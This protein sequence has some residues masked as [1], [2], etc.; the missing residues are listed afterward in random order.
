MSKFLKTTFSMIFVSLSILSCS[1]NLLDTSNYK[2]TDN[3]TI[4]NKEEID[5]LDKEYSQFNTKA[6]TDGYLK[7]KLSF[8]T[9]TNNSNKLKK[10]LYYLSYRQ[11]NIA[12]NLLD[13]EVQLL[14][15]INN[16]SGILSEK[17]INQKFSSVF[18]DSP[19]TCS[20]I[21]DK[22][23]FYSSTK[24]GRDIETPILNLINTYQSNNITLLNGNETL[25]NSMNILENNMN[26]NIQNFTTSYD[27]LK[28]SA[29]SISNT[30]NGL[31][32]SNSAQ[33]QSQIVN[34]SN[35]FTTLKT[36]FNSFKQSFESSLNQLNIQKN[37]FSLKRNTDSNSMNTSLSI[38]SNKQNVTNMDFN[39]I[40]SVY[41]SCSFSAQENNSYQNLYQ[42][43][44][45]RLYS[46][47]HDIQYVS[48]LIS[49]FNQNYMIRID[50]ISNKLNNMNSIHQY[51]TNNF[52]N[53]FQ[54]IQ[55]TLQDLNNM[56]QDRYS[57]LACN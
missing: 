34:L 13:K 3:S 15:Q 38:I 33:I 53:K 46:S 24:F 19:A 4:L 50:N 28:N 40:N 54:E 23:S 41:N 55:Y 39:N 8:L 22:L 30:L 12:Y 36:S 48:Q 57:N 1:N 25:M 20:N 29:Y 31:T 52:Y 44:V 16:V 51:N 35:N 10:E 32:C 6:L 37:T 43:L 14:Q 45:N 5:L 47:Q 42:T 9:T 18:P 2:D 17:N 26:I 11:K 21:L 56:Y 7:S 49:Q 27:N